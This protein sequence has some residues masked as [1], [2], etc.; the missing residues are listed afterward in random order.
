MI[1]KG[2]AGDCAPP[3]RKPRKGEEGEELTPDCSRMT[4][5]PGDDLG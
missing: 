4:E 2:T 3:A 1:H 5:E